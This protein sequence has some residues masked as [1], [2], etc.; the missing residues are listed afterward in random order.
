MREKV[1]ILRRD[2][3]DTNEG[4]EKEGLK[5]AKARIKE[6][7]EKSLSLH[8]SRVNQI[9]LETLISNKV[10]AIEE[11]HRVCDQFRLLRTRIIQHMKQNGLRTIMVSG[12]GFQEGKSTI[13]ANLAVTFSKEINCTSL[14]VDLDFRN[15]AIHRIFGIGSHSGGL[16]DYLLGQRSMEEIFV[17]PGIDKL[18][19]LPAGRDVPNAPELLGSP[20]MKDMVNE[21][22]ERYPDRFVIFDVPSASKSPAPLIV[23]EHIDAILLVARKGVTKQAEVK[24]VMGLIPKAKILGLVFNDV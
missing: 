3:D 16:T 17:R 7:E 9:P 6:Q 14:L 20:S 8:T 18:S 10:F 4:I 11:K 24:Q 13:A 23:S 22:R 19:I 21:L 15:S 5:V 2:G 1:K 12:F